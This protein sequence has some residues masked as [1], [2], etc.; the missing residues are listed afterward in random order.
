MELRCRLDHAPAVGETAT[1]CNA[2]QWPVLRLRVAEVPEPPRAGAEWAA[3]A[4]EPWN[5]DD[6]LSDEAPLPVA[7]APWWRA[8]VQHVHVGRAREHKGW[9]VEQDVVMLYRRG[10]DDEDNATGDLFA[11]NEAAS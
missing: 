8:K 5:E 11:G 7:G 4:V 1:L 2:E 6:L 10:A 9:I 3:M